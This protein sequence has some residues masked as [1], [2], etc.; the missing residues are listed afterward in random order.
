MKK[1]TVF[2]AVVIFCFGVLYSQEKAS[3]T[4]QLSLMDCI[5]KA[6]EDNLD[7]AVQAYDPAIADLSVNQ[8]R[9]IY[10]PQVNFLYTNYSY[11]NS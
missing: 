3:E 4:V 1:T 11:N 10:W 6:M 7:I 9:E 8:A 2:I 5:L